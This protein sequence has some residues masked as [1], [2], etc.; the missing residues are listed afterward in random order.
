MQVELTEQG[1]LI[2]KPQIASRL[3]KAEIFK[4]VE[5]LQQSL[6]TTPAVVELMRQTDRY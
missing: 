6:P 5:R 2:L 3:D 4:L 1:A